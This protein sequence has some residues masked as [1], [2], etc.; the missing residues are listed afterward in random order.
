M[1]WMRVIEMMTQGIVTLG[2]A[3]LGYLKLKNGLDDNTSTTNRIAGE[4]ATHAAKTD[5]KLENIQATASATHADVS[6]IKENGV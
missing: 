6:K 2:L 5:R 4:L 3:Y 1:D